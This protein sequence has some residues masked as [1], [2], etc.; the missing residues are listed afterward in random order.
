VPEEIEKRFWSSWSPR[1]RE[2]IAAAMKAMFC[3]NLTVNTQRHVL[4][5][6]GPSPGTVDVGACRIAPPAAEDN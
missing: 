5:G 1:D 4:K 3:V 6:L 2:H